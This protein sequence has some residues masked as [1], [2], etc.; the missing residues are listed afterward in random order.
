MTEPLVY[1]G[2]RYQNQ[3]YYYCGPTPSKAFNWSPMKCDALELLEEQAQHLLT[4]Y[5]RQPHPDN[6]T[7]F[8]EKVNSEE[9]H[10]NKE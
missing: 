3:T 2:L 4:K 10:D 6:G 1:L 8:V 5:K 7:P 9:P